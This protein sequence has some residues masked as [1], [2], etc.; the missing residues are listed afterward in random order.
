MKKQM[1]LASMLSTFAAAEAQASLQQEAESRGADFHDTAVLDKTVIVSNEA[2]LATLLKIRDAK[3]EGTHHGIVIPGLP[4]GNG[5]E[6]CGT[7]SQGGTYTQTANTDHYIQHDHY[8]PDGR[9]LDHDFHRI[10][11]V[12]LREILEARVGLN[13]EALFEAPKMQ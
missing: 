9:I 2:L 1:T 5:C 3:R 6:A 12:A 7:Y 11:E 8:D 4:G 10:N 13:L